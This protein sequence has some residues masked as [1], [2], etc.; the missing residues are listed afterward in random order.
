M[1]IIFQSS[2]RGDKAFSYFCIRFKKIH[3]V[4][5]KNEVSKKE[6]VMV[7]KVR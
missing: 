4:T 6:I 5:V 1:I 2:R 7:G 3:F